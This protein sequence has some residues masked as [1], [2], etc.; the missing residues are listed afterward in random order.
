MINRHNICR[1]I[2]LASLLILAIG[3]RQTIVAQTFVHP[4]TLHTQTDFDRMKAKVQAGAHPWI[5]SWNILV[6]SGVSSNYTPTPMPILQRGSGGGACLPSDNYQYAYWDTEA[7]YQLALR[8]KITGDNN[9][10]N[11]VT[12]I[13]NQWA[14]VC[15]NLCGDPNITLLEIYGYQFACVGEI[16]RSYT[17]WNAADVTQFQVWMVNLWYPM[18]H[19][20]LS[21]HDGTCSTYMWAN[22]DLCCMDSMM[23]IGIL[24]DDT[25]TCNEAL[26]YFKAGIG[27]GNIEQTVYNMFPGYLGQGQEEGRDQG[28]SGLEVALLGVFCTMAY[29]QGNDLFAYQNNRVLSLCEYFAKYNLY[30]NVPYLPYDNC[31]G[32]YQSNVANNS[33]GDSRPC[34]DLIYNHYV[35]LKGIAAPW[36]AQY[37]ANLRPDG[38]GGNGDEL[39]FTTLTCSLDPIVVGANPSGLT[40][41]LSG[42]QRIQLNWWGTANATNYLVKRSTV[43][44]GS[45]TT[46]ATITTN[47]LTYTDANVTN[48]VTYYYTVSALTPLGESGNATEVNVGVQPQLVAYYKFN[49]ASGTNAADAT[50]NGWTGTLMNGASWAVGHSNNCVNLS[51][52]SQQYV[53]LPSGITTNLNDFTIAA[54]VNLASISTWMRI[55]DFGVEQSA[56]WG[57]TYYS[58]PTRY[59]LLTPQSSSGAVRFTITTGGGGVEQIINGTSALLVGSWHHVAVTLAGTTGTLYVDATPVGT[60]SITITPAQ[61]GTTT[62]NSIGKSLYSSDPYL[63]GKVD[64][65]RIY[66]GALS[67]AQIAALAASY[68]MQ[69]P[70]PTN[71]VATAASANQ[72]NL[73]WS[74]SLRATN[75]CV[76]RST[77]TGGPYT[78]ISAPLTVTNFSDTSLAGGTTYYYVIAA[79]NDGGATNSVEVSATTLTAPSAPAS[80]T[81]VAG[82]SGTINLSWPASAGATSYNIKRANFSG[83]PYNVIATNVTTIGYTNTGLDG[84]VTY[85]YV[86]SAVNVNG[87][88]PNSSEASA[89]V[90]PIVWQAGANSNWDIG[91][92]TNWLAGGLP[93]TYQDGCAVQFNDSA[94]S[95]TVNLVANVSPISVTFS[96]QTQNYTINGSGFG[97]GGPATL[98]TLGSGSVTLNGP[99]TFSGDIALNGS[100]TL[101]IGGAG[102]LGDGNYAANI[103]DYSTLNY[104]SS[105]AQTLSSVISGSGGL[106][107]RGSSTLTLSGANTYSGTTT[108]GAGKLSVPSGGQITSAG[109]GGGNYIVVGNA[110]NQN[111]ILNIAGGA[112]NLFTSSGNAWA[113]YL[114]AGNGSSYRGFV[115]MTSGTLNPQRHFVLGNNGGYGAMSM[116]GGTL[117]VGSY[118]I[119]GLYQ[120]S[121]GGYGVFN[122]TGG[123]VTQYQTSGNGA[124]LIGSGNGSLG[125]MNLSGGTFDASAGGIFLPENGTSTGVLNISGTASVTAGNVGVQMGNSSSAI[126]GTLNLLGGTLAANSIQSTGGTS[127]VNFNGGTLKA[128]AAGTTFM[129]GLS[130]AYVLGNGGTI[131]NGSNNITVSQPLLT[132]TGSGLAGVSSISVANQGS[133]YLNAPIVTISGG[134]VSTAGATAVANLVDDGT[135]NGTYKVGSFTITSPGV[136]TVAPTTVALT[137][138]GASTAASGF[139]ISTSANTSGGMTFAGSGTTTLAGV[140]TYTGATTVANGTLK[141]NGP[142]LYLSFDN[143]GGTTVTNQ[144]AAGATMNGTLTG[145]ASIVSGGRRGNALQITGTAKNAGYVLITGSGG[146]TMN[147][148]AGA[149]W[150]V[151]YWLKTT[152]PGAITMYQGNGSWNNNTGGADT[153]VYCG[154]G[155]PEILGSSTHV[156][157]VSYGR[158]WEEGTATIT[159]GN[160]HFI[161]M[162]CNGTTK[163]NYVDGAVDAL[164]QNSLS[165]T[166]EGNQVWIGGGPTAIGDAV[167]GLNGGLIDEFYMFNRALSQTEVTNLMNGTPSSPAIPAASAVTV[168]ASAT[169]DLNGFGSTIA[170]LNGGGTVDTT[171]T[172]F[173][174]TLTINNNAGAAFSGVVKNS[175]NLLS[176]I[177][178]GSG[179]QTLTGT[180]I[181][182]GTTTISNGELVV[183]TTFAGNGNFIVRDGATLGV[184]NL[185]NAQSAGISNLTLGVSGTTTLEF[186]N[187]SNLTKPLIQLAGSVTLNGTSTIK[188]TGTNNLVA[189]MTYP[190]INYSG[191][192]TGS[193]SALQL[194]IPT[195]MSGTL[196]SNANS[197]AL[198]IL[199]PPA[200][201]AGLT[202]TAGNAQVWLSWNAAAAANSYY[203]KNSTTNG[204]PYSVAANLPGLAFTNTGLANGTNYYFIV[205]ATN[206]VGESTN[207][208]PVSARPVSPASPQLISGVSS[209][210]FQFTWPP[211]HTGW[212]LQVQ[213]NPLASGLGTN[214]L[215]VPNS[216]NVNQYSTSINPTNGSVF[217]RLVYP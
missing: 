63:N 90:V 66:N 197:V 191:G 154:S 56:V 178:T 76:K 127:A 81:A 68:P 106:T 132:A 133:G 203:V 115:N 139:T 98:T 200:A 48:G 156:G 158:N 188:I 60:N 84:T 173:A 24:C 175:G 110:A 209:S 164:Q 54:W 29:H 142:V 147:V 9:Y 181:Y 190:L 102:N 161:V 87:E 58:T 151:A 183:S 107:K 182:S 135:G 83:G 19:A 137:G 165:G 134:T 153:L 17:N 108:V 206:A 180:N 95:T 187:V 43:S 6:N 2:Y 174:P 208:L 20:F 64:D 213:T 118:F 18:D 168:A 32:V 50:G 184:T 150:T 42:A 96:N 129:Q 145:T 121:A 21:A 52:N 105:G 46:L 99:N 23:A 211:D 77:V 31:D 15:T 140:N 116:S 162:T 40:A 216:T 194:S 119:L 28:H 59:M 25:N 41:K 143:V 97:I 47:L 30:N 26:T 128:S 217:F 73:I 136:Y 163:V 123:A 44:G 3:L 112:V 92:A 130:C 85:Y 109:T 157:I 16:M 195:G 193:F 148:A 204:G 167:Q 212:R 74:P 12:N 91:V 51:S 67:A 1:K 71:I 215:T 179:T 169:L 125:V 124:T 144:G 117:T 185:G 4:G 5:D 100:G 171:S 94:L 146:P 111:A 166:A 88:S 62:Q 138:G 65:F 39:G 149:Q 14:T 103:V 198:S 72:I 192:F 172:N 159:D 122:Q 101:T 155:T 196:V 89:T 93:G 75:Y 13:L 86:V 45:Y 70:A 186:Q 80:L 202:A 53:S 131:D 141:L 7:G 36:S 210:Q 113:S 33:Q 22:W 27:N 37:A 126:S 78:T 189:G 49:E 104:N 120:D 69:P 61:L 8:W 114:Q 35:N 177:K 57:S 176:L 11:A 82:L 38:S 10:A 152:T 160:W 55:F 34:W 214:W 79:A 207:S 170:G 201:P 199:A 205:T